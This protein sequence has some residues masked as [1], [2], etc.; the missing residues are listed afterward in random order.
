MKLFCDDLEIDEEAFIHSCVCLN[1]RTKHLRH[2]DI[3][4]DKANK[5]ANEVLSTPG[6]MEHQYYQRHGKYPTI[7]QNSA[8]EQQQFHGHT[9]STI[10]QC[11]LR[12]R[13]T[14]QFK[15]F[16]QMFHCTKSDLRRA[17]K[18]LQTHNYDPRLAGG[19]WTGGERAALE[20]VLKLDG[21]S[22]S[23]KDMQKLKRVAEEIGVN[24]DLDEAPEMI[25]LLD[26]P[27]V[28]T[29][30]YLRPLH[31]GTEETQRAN[32][33]VRSGSSSS[34]DSEDERRMTKRM[35]LR[36]KLLNSRWALLRL[37][38]GARAVQNPYRLPDR[39]ASGT[40]DGLQQL[41]PPS[42]LDHRPRGFSPPRWHR[43]SSP[44]RVRE[45]GRSLT[46]REAFLESHPQPQSSNCSINEQT[47]AVPGVQGAGRGIK[48]KLRVPKGL[49]ADL[50]GKAP[51][52]ETLSAVTTTHDL[53]T[54]VTAVTPTILPLNTAEV[55]SA[56]STP[57]TLVEQAEVSTLKS[58]VDLKDGV[59]HG[60]PTQKNLGFQ[61]DT[62]ASQAL[63]SRLG[64]DPI[65]PT[66]E[67]L[68]ARIREF[69][70]V[71]AAATPTDTNPDPP[72]SPT[73]AQR[74]IS[75]L[76]DKILT[77]GSRAM[78]DSDQP[79]HDSLGS[80]VNQLRRDSLDSQP[81]TPSTPIF[82]SITP[83]KTSPPSP[84]YNPAL[85]PETALLDTTSTCNQSQAQIT[86]EGSLVTPVSASTENPTQALPIQD[87]DISA[88]IDLGVVLP[89]PKDQVPTPM[90]TTTPMSDTT[91]SADFQTPRT[92]TT[93][94]AR[95]K[96][97]TIPADTSEVSQQILQDRIPVSTMGED[98]EMVLIG[99]EDPH[100][101][102][103]GKLP[104]QRQLERVRSESTRRGK[105][106]L[107]APRP[108]SGN[109]SRLAT[110]T[111]SKSE[112]DAGDRATSISSFA[113]TDE[114]SSS[115]NYMTEDDK[116][117]P[118]TKKRK[119]AS[120]KKATKAK[121]AA[122]VKPVV[123][124]PPQT[125]RSSSNLQRS[126]KPSKPSTTKSPAKK[127]AVLK[128]PQGKPT[129]TKKENLPPTAR[130]RSTHT[131]TSTTT[132]TV[133]PSS[134]ETTPTPLSIV[135][136]LGGTPRKSSSTTH[137]PQNTT[138]LGINTAN[139]P[140][141]PSRSAPGHKR[142]ISL[143]VK[144][145]AG[146]SDASSPS[147]KPRLKSPAPASPDP[148]SSDVTSG[149]TIQNQPGTKPRTRSS[150]LALSETMDGNTDPSDLPLDSE[151]RPLPTQPSSKPLP[152]STKSVKNTTLKPPP[153]TPLTRSVARTPIHNLRSGS[154]G[155]TS[156]PP[157][158]PKQRV[159]SA[160]SSNV[161]GSA[162]T[163]KEKETPKSPQPKNSSDPNE[164]PA[165][166]KFGWGG[167]RIKG[168]GQ[169]NHNK[170]K[171]GK[172]GR[173]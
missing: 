87:Q 127:A 29:G 129:A 114:D 101:P 42:N 1:E 125:R 25:D 84:A 97:G 22:V 47:A 90:R 18:F 55:I 67:P 51:A 62:Q 21:L 152:K 138:S 6:L 40:G 170:R 100:P 131:N 27:F 73:T 38:D 156:A 107:S 72:L 141:G 103:R 61:V 26:G 172:E 157:A 134:A 144:E 19:G 109:S 12:N 33:L 112:L 24:L 64:E 166:K 140:P 94:Y 117:K 146:S 79:S 91:T 35:I 136:R 52:T 155:S 4:I 3:L 20:T 116:A 43:R 95:E 98:G 111:A 59:R 145:Q 154:T 104:I 66:P 78:G 162:S 92:G 110:P 14:L 132:S 133:P 121:P 81:K 45:R 108:P 37:R 53:S 77:T 65:P 13:D 165:P 85:L 164:S 147:K 30:H 169:G 160:R 142:R 158:P 48:L 36:F 74:A 161:G 151:T 15:Q 143:I 58:A 10:D 2:E 113:P 120:A 168:S 41:S 9:L 106:T 63:L 8:L 119:V 96:H 99:V 60:E 89:G 75:S 54:Q 126:E 148:T 39:Y 173:T 80:F 57:T 28:S 23:K 71:D 171:L 153:H 69:P 115:A 32:P 123:Y 122:P 167:L 7:Q 139:F 56:V 150:I 130:R 46:P 83:E 149:S 82:E 159:Q 49:L 50:V 105:L 34:T 124:T 118:N 128:S 5:Q 102:G 31:L 88:A 86:G 44:T 163:E 76:L 70:I 135:D 93:P 11:I 17:Q 68:T 137:A 16:D